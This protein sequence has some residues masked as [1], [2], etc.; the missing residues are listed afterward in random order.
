[1]ISKGVRRATYYRAPLFVEANLDPHYWPFRG[2]VWSFVVHASIFAALV[3]ITLPRSRA[4]R[5]LRDQAVI[6]DIDEFKEVLYLPVLG[7]RERNTTAPEPAR[8]TR[9]A[10]LQTR[11]TAG[12]SYPGPQPI[13]SDVENPTNHTQTLLQPSLSNPFV[14]QQQP[15]L[16]NIVQLAEASPVLKP[17]TPPSIEPRFKVPTATAPAAQPLAAHPLDVALTAPTKPLPAP[18]AESK[19]NVPESSAVAAV[20]QTAAPQLDV[21]SLNGPARPL[22]APL[23][24]SRIKVPESSATVTVQRTENPQLDLHSLNG[25]ARPLAAPLAESKLAVPAATSPVAQRTATPQ[26]DVA[27]AGPNKPLAAPRVES[28]FRVPDASAPAV[29]QPVPP[30]PQLDVPLPNT[31]P[32]TPLR[33]PAEL[34]AKPNDSK[35]NL[36]ALSPMPGRGD[37]PVAVPAGE[38]R[39]RFAISPD[40]NLDFPGLEPGFKDGNDTGTRSSAPAPENPTTPATVNNPF[41]GIVILGAAVD[42]PTSKNTPAIRNPEPLQ[43]SYGI[44][45][46]ASGGSGG[47]LPDLGVFKN[48][49]VH[50]VYLDMRRTVSDSAPSWTVEYALAPLTPATPSDSADARVSTKDDVVLPFPIVKEQPPM[51]SEMVS[52]YPRRMIIVFGIINVEGKLEELDIKDTPNHLLDLPVLNSLRNWT[53]RPARRNGEVVPVKALFGIPL[54]S[55][56]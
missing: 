46:L 38:A 52:R 25:P 18:R 50:T 13:L 3:S 51:A 45:L 26:L 15:L 8:E 35:Q 19:F 10:T 37:Q 21:L 12:L 30:A 22:A 17:L 14:L 44:T 9:S 55:P 42:P 7:D 33:A 34:T 53:F 41:P 20:R 2:I 23:A 1:M 6:L 48:E 56:E 36:L 4:E 43:T 39:G 40:P 16:P 28:K 24:E 47:G 31:V 29:Q 32:A 49:Q 27:L 54:W 11:K 5:S